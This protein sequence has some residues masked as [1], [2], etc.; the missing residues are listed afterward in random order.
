MLQ[1]VNKNRIN[2]FNL[3]YKLMSDLKTSETERQD[4][5]IT[6]TG[7]MLDGMGLSIHVLMF[8]TFSTA[9]FVRLIY[10]TDCFVGYRKDYSESLIIQ[11]IF[12]YLNI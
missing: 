11:N 5:K 3:K 10:N 6:F 7:E 9:C 2:D 12:I 8:I 1:Q 4:Y